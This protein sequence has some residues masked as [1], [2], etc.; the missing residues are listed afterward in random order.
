VTNGGNTGVSDVW[1]N[2]FFFQDRV[3]F[4]RQWSFLLGARIDAVQDHTQDPFGGVD[5]TYCYTSLPNGD[6]LPE[7]HTT[8]LYGLGDLNTSLVYRPI[9]QVTTYL[10]FDWTQSLNPNGGDGGINAYLQVPDSEL[11]RATSFL[12]EA[13]IK[14]NLFNNRLFV[15]GA[16]F[17]Q[18]HGVPTGPGGT[19]TDMANIR[20]VEVETNYQPNRNLFVTASYSY[21]DTTL[22]NPATFYDYPA[23]LGYNVDGGGN[24]AV[25][26]SGQKFQD[27]GQPQH[28]FNFLGNYKF[29]IG[30][31]L[32]FGVQVTGPIPVTTSGQLVPP[33]YSTSTQTWSG[34]QFVP[35]S[36][37]ANNYYYQSP[38][39]PWQYTMN[40]AVFYEWK[41]YSI[42]LSCYNFTNQ[43]NWQ[44]SPAY[45]GNDFLVQNDPRTWE[46]RLQAKF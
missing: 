28:V 41:H 5:C 38:V 4:S 36:V 35:A 8:G 24:F 29:P 32:R 26:A 17:D 22:N 11:M 37:A 40:A 15:G 16:V 7:S 13:G 12:Y 1:D 46:V 3:Q 42:T 31:G 34:S 44:P 18:K 2:A 45:Y 10:T 20:G 43:R 19:I 25:F 23:Q 30:I 33:T 14:L 39:I 27:P 6:P 9:S 21:I